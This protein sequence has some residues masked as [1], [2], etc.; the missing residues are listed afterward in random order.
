M[1]KIGAGDA[2]VR[3]QRFIQADGP[4]GVGDVEPIKLQAQLTILPNL[5]RIIR[6]EVQL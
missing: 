2:T 1:D 6:P 4:L 5:D 3:V